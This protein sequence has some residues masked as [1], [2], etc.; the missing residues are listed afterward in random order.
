MTMGQVFLLSVT[1]QPGLHT[2]LHLHVAVTRW[3]KGE[4]WEPS[5][6]QCYSKIVGHWLEKNFNFVIKW[7]NV[8]V[9]W[10]SV[11]HNEYDF[12]LPVIERHNMVMN[13]ILCLTNIEV[14]FLPI[15][16]N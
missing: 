5:I 9:V 6:N 12:S 3:T 1:F 8:F 16:I 15:C 2:Y 4:A 11:Q 10:R 13:L 14:I 7:L